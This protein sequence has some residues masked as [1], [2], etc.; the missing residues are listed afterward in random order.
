MGGSNEKENLVS[1]YP[2]EHFLAHLLLV[3]IY[4]ENKKLI[5]CVSMMCADGSKSR[6]AGKRQRYLYG[7]LKRR[8]SEYMKNLNSGEKNSNFGTRWISS[9][10]LKKSKKIKKNESIPFGWI[11]GRNKWKSIEYTLCLDCNQSTQSTKAK[12]CF[13][14]R[15]SHFDTGTM[16][17]NHYINFRTPEKEKSRREKIS[18]ARM[19]RELQK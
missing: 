18:L 1:L 13:S 14:C 6:W 16:K 2:E 12:Y 4:P 11:L 7:W 9:I 3:K 10:E 17:N 5:S 8:H 19:R 15:K